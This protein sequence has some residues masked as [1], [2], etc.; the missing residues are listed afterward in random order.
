MKV[1]I[2]NHEEHWLTLRITSRKM[3]A[4]PL[5]SPVLNIYIHPRSKT[6]CNMIFVR[7]LFYS[8]LALSLHL[9]SPFAVSSIDYSNSPQKVELLVPRQRHLGVL[10]QIPEQAGGGRLLRP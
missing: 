7:N 6:L 8:N 2:K 4:R 10:P 5:L 9:S 1:R 3:N